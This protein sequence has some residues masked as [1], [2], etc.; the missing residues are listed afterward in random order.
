[1]SCE[2]CTDPD[3]V[4]CMPIYGVAP[5]THDVFGRTIPMPRDQWAG[6]FREDKDCPGMG[7]YWCQYCGDGKPNDATEPVIRCSIHN[8]ACQS[9]PA[10]GVA[11]CIHRA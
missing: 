1:M 10:C 3:G 9:E 2:Y 11:G 7:L 6:N 5:H 4:P 8:R